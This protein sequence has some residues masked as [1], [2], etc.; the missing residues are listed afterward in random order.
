MSVQPVYSRKIKKKQIGR[1]SL[2]SSSFLNHCLNLV[3]RVKKYYKK[4]TPF[5]QII[6]KESTYL[7]GQSLIILKMKTP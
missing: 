6:G 3:K 2:N 7:F 5:I 4:R 1:I